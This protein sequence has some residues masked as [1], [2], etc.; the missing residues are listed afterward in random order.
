MMHTQHAQR[1]YSDLEVRLLTPGSDLLYPGGRVTRGEPLRS[2]ACA[3]VHVR[4]REVRPF[5][6]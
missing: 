1:Q 4:A 2:G 3:G 5:A 6:L